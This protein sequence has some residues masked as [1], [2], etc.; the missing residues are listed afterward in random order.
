[1]FLDHYKETGSQEYLSINCF[2]SMDNLF[3]Y[4]LNIRIWIGAIATRILKLFYD[5][6]VV[7]QLSFVTYNMSS[8]NSHILLDTVRHRILFLIL[9]QSRIRSIFNQIRNL[10]LD[11]VNLRPGSRQL[12]TGSGQPQ[13]QIRSISNQIRNRGNISNERSVRGGNTLLFHFPL[14]IIFLWFCCHEVGSL[15]KKVS[16][17]ELRTDRTV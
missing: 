9:R 12:Q 6:F 10:N 16:Q 4:F 7:L 13:Y 1:M 2:A 14:L 5:N 8:N 11:P 15:D 3:V 17:K